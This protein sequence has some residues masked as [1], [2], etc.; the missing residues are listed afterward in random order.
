MICLEV[1]QLAGQCT[2][3]FYNVTAKGLTLFCLHKMM[4]VHEGRNHEVRELVK[5][6]GLQVSVC[7]I[8]DIIYIY[9]E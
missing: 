8:I 6:A 7:S 4:Q 1:V 2:C 9:F 3:I 5:N